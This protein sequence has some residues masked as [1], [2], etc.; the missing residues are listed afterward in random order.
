MAM[1][2]GKKTTR[3]W[4][5]S[6]SAATT[7]APMTMSRHEYAATRWISGLTGREVPLASGMPADTRTC[8]RS[9]AAARTAR[10]H[11][12]MV[13]GYGGSYRASV[14][15]DADPLQQNRLAVVVPEV[16]GDAAAWASA[17]MGGAESLPA[18]GDTVWIS[19]EQGDTDYPVWQLQQGQ[20]DG[21]AEGISRY[22]GKYRGTV[23]DNE[24]PLEQRRL[25]VSVPE[26]DASAAWATAGV[27]SFDGD[28]L[29][30]VGSEV[31]I[32]YEYGD[33]AYP[34]WVGLA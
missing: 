17:S 31:W 33:A 32:E 1:T 12:C 22:I 11:E 20:D 6:H 7:T 28:D 10:E 23:V 16:Y 5:S 3:T 2:S 25:E 26:V 9:T 13:S 24:D 21:R 14:V 34:R 30:Q 15:D 19:F 29:P 27:D 8:T 18:I 4:R